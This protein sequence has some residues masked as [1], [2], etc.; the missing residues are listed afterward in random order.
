M[1]HEQP[2]VQCTTKIEKATNDR[3][4]STAGE[5]RHT[6]STAP[7]ITRENPE[8]LP[9]TP[10]PPRD[11]AHKRAEPQA[12]TS[13]LIVL[14][15]LGLSQTRV[16]YTHGIYTHTYQKRSLFILFRM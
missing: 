15:R 12:Y 10:Q 11:G 5:P 9:G 7:W 3:S 2:R 4:T 8:G 13:I 14:V 16:Y 6:R 1:Q